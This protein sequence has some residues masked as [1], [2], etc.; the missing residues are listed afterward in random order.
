LV[1]QGEPAAMG[2][3]LALFWAARELMV[4]HIAPGAL[5]ELTIVSDLKGR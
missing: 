5:L 3:R 1:N 2:C 4:H